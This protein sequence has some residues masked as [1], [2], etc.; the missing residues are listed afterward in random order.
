MGATAPEA[1]RRRRDP[2][3]PTRLRDAAPSAR[4][5]YLLLETTPRPLSQADVRSLTGLSTDATRRALRALMG[6]D[7][8]DEQ[9]HPEDGRKRLYVL[10]RGDGAGEVR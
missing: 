9:P 8:V 10:G 5:V 7:V 2:R 1:E 6:A 3:V 4:L